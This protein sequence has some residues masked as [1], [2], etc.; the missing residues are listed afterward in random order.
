MVGIGF[1][2]SSTVLNSSTLTFK[3]L[4]GRRSDYPGTISTVL[5][6]DPTTNITCAYFVTG[7]FQEVSISEAFEMMSYQYLE[8]NHPLLLAVLIAEAVLEYI[9][10]WMRNLHCEL[11]EIEKLTEIGSA[12]DVEIPSRQVITILRS[13]SWAC[14]TAISISARQLCS[15]SKD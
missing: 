5:R 8:C 15:L 7:S 6:Y 1:L 9:T 2:T 4:V 14:Y 13:E 10:K 12:G 11:K 3:V